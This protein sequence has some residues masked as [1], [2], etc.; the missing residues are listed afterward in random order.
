MFNNTMHRVSTDQPIEYATPF[1]IRRHQDHATRRPFGPRD[2]AVERFLGHTL[3]STFQPIF[4]LAHRGVVGHEA[5]LRVH[6]ESGRSISPLAFF[7]SEGHAK[8][9]LY[10][11]WLSR[12]L[13]LRNF[14]RQSNGQD[15]WLFLNFHPNVTRTGKSRQFR[16]T[17][18][19]LRI[20]GIEPNRVVVEILEQGFHDESRIV[21]IVDHYRSLGCLIAVDDFGAGEANFDR[22]WKLKA[23]IVK[24]DRSL[25]VQASQ[26]A[27]ARAFL[28]S[29]STMLHQAGKLVLL[30]GI[31]TEE[32]TL[33]AMDADVD[34]V[35]GYHLAR[36][37]PHLTPTRAAEPLLAHLSGQLL[38]RERAN[39]HIQ[40]RELNSRIGDFLALFKKKMTGKETDRHEKRFEKYLKSPGVRRCFV[41]DENG[42]QI[43]GNLQGSSRADL[44]RRPL[45]PLTD[46]RGADWSRRDYFRRAMRYFGQVQVTGP[47]FS[48]PDAQDCVTLSLAM[49][50][51]NG[52]IRVYCCDLAWNRAVR[53]ELLI[54]SHAG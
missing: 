38:D 21:E 10:T 46:A 18:E 11:D 53:P 48:L 20:H 7:H 27:R 12:C 52:Q 36:P 25:I 35:Q 41:L 42:I 1:D 47:Y 13:H 54:H 6:D 30:E 37:T 45:T 43:G 19:L 51:K 15:G 8:N 5:L 44:S 39:A 50:H 23:D 22:I 26:D 3:S 16:F 32:Q 24:L 28:S 49:R 9:L 40:T 17:E 2:H 29:I 31:E 4:G 34:F 33:I 14:V